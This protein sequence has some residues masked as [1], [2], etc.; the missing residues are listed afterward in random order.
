MVALGYVPMHYVDHYRNEL[1]FNRR[2]R[3]RDGDA[4]D[5]A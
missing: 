3:S 2:D 1:S 5:L 4:S